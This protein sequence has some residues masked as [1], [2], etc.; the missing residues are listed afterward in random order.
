MYM[1]IRG[2]TNTDIRGRM[3]ADVVVRTKTDAD[4][5]W[6]LSRRMCTY[7]YMNER[8][9]ALGGRTGAR[10]RKICGAWPAKQ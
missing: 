10:V 7:M 8:T 9:Q 3:N 4:V 1:Y 6:D 5:L 2:R